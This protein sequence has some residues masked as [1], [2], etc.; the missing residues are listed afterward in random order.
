MDI[1]HNFFGSALLTHLIPAE[2]PRGIE[3]ATPSLPHIYIIVG[4]TGSN[5]FILMHHSQDGA[6]TLLSRKLP[7]IT[8]AGSRIFSHHHVKTPNKY[9]GSLKKR[10]R[11]QSRTTKPILFR[12]KSLNSGERLSYFLFFYTPNSLP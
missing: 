9:N 3:F 2:L 7:V 10:M 5:S 4:Q 12:E 11:S 8:L 6:P 1:K